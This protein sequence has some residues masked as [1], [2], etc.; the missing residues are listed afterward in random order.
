MQNELYQ[1]QTKQFFA[2]WETLRH[3]FFTD[4]KGDLIRTRGFSTV[5]Q[6]KDW[7]YYKYPERKLVDSEDNIIFNNKNE[8]CF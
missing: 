1:V 4:S 3:Y 2:S 7:V 6:A 8:N 5:K